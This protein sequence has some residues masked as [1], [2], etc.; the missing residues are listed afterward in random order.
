[1]EELLNIDTSQLNAMLRSDGHLIMPIIR[2]VSISD[3][4]KTVRV[5]IGGRCPLCCAD[6][7]RNTCNS[8]YCEEVILPFLK[9]NYPGKVSVV[10]PVFTSDEDLV[11]ICKSF[12]MDVSYPIDMDEKLPFH[13]VRSFLSH[14]APPWLALAT[15]PGWLVAL[16]GT[17]GRIC[18]L[19]SLANQ[20]RDREDRVSPAAAAG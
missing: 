8:T 17:L 7:I 13:A 2:F 12:D 18:P 9:K 11:D 3:V 15:L 4:T 19:I 20:P 5:L 14:P 16:R 10:K 1:M 6:H